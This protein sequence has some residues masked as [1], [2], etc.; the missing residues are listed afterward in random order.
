MA[1]PRSNIDE[2]IVRAARVLFLRDGV[3]GASLRDIARRARTSI[4]MIYYYFPTKDDLFLGVIEQ[5]YGKLLADFALALASAPTAEGRLRALYARIAVASEDELDV[6]RLIVREALVS[7]D[8]R[9]RILERFSRGHMPLLLHALAE[10][11]ERGEVEAHPLPAL[12]MVTIAVGLG[13]QLVRRLMGD[14][15]PF[16]SLPQGEEL[17][18]S[19][20]DLLFEGLRPR[21]R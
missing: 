8:R 18:G 6:I 10:G 15:E 14:R 11:V 4:G 13:P 20:A 3:D 5:V 9:T 17:A 19:L 1:R 2:R 16:A 21:H 12:L 7:S